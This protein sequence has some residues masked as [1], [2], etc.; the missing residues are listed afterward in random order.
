M[1]R[2][3]FLTSIACLPLLSSRTIP[4]L[5]KKTRRAILT[6]ANYEF[7]FTYQIEPDG[8][9]MIDALNRERLRRTLEM[10]NLESELRSLPS[11]EIDRDELCLLRACS[12]D[13]VAK[14]LIGK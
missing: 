10:P 2:R 11:L 1:N 5:S 3:N 9:V 13:R 6:L 4:T 14:L 7:G 12:S 8:R